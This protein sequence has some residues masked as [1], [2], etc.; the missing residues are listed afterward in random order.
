MAQPE[1]WHY[2]LDICPSPYIYK[3]TEQ[4][5]DVF[6][7]R[8]IWKSSRVTCDCDLWAS[9]SEASCS[10][11]MCRPNDLIYDYEYY[12]HHASC[13]KSLSSR[14]RQQ[15]L[16][17]LRLLWWR[18]NSSINREQLCASALPTKDL[19]EKAESLLPTSPFGSLSLATSFLL[20]FFSPTSLLFS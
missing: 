18:W 12:T 14:S 2:L 19:Q 11:L 5:L 9:E 13:N 10:L 15:I 17:Q 4:H 7:F 8:F 3:C 20:F 16:R 1:L 6:L